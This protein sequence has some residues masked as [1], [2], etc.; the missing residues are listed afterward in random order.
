M[1]KE[2]KEAGPRMLCKRTRGSPPGRNTIYGRTPRQTMSSI[3]SR[4]G[5]D[6]PLYLG[7]V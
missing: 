5:K 7:G 3:P 4:I 2:K 6:R 1:V